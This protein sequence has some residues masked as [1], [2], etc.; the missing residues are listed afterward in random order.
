M[1]GAV[2]AGGAGTRLRAEGLGK[3]AALLAGRPLLAYPLAALAASCD[4]VAVVCKRDTRLPRIGAAERWEEPDEPRHP[5]TGIVHA[6]ARAAAPV[7]V[8]AADT[9]FVTPEACRSLLSAAA[10]SGAPATVAV[11]GERLQPVFGVYSPT[12]LETLEAAVRGA[13]LTATVERLAPARVAL[14]APLLR[15]VDTP[16]DLAAAEASVRAA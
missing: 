10:R 2:L 5:L 8:C 6:L 3:P 15:S 13:P 7:L 12:A 14:P 4:R 16:E 11:A 1:I 9:P